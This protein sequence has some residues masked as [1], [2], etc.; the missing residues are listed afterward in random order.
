MNY[1]GSKHRLSDFIYSSIQSVI[2]SNSKVF[3]DIFAG[4]GSIG[5]KFKKAG[6]KVISNDIQYYS[7][8]LNRHYIGNNKEL[9]FD[10]LTNI[11]N[12]SDSSSK[13][14]PDIVCNYLSGIDEVEGFIYSNYSYDGTVDKEFRREYFSAINAMKC[15]AIRLTIEEWKQSEKINDDEYFFLLTTLLEA[16]DKRAN[17]ASVYGAFLKKIKRSAQIELKLIPADTIIDNLDHN[18][19]NQDANQLIKT[20]ESDILYLDPPYNARQYSANYHLLETISRYDNPVVKGKTGLRDYSDQ[21][22]RYCIKSEVKDI[23]RDLIL[24]AKTRYIF[25]SYNNEGLLS[26]DDIREILSLRGDY[27]CFA[28]DYNRYKADA[29]REYL[30]DK[31]VEYLHYVI[32]N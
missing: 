1:I 26:S 6:Y 3:C 27:G 16:I 17:T 8:I 2:D 5:I 21:K 12:L 23:F 7:Y 18:V 14:R 11:L 15:D 29:T 10:G 24:N 22:S 13:S 32:V 20:I 4:T 19:F 28:K 9:K 25:L 30:S 31:T